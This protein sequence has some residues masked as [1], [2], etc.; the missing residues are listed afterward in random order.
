M[1][2]GLSGRKFNRTSGERKALLL[3][4]AC[5]LIKHEQIKTTLPKAKDLRPYVEKLI[6]IAAKDSL[7]SRRHALIN[8]A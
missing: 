6:T 2:H 3:N 7:A 5:S 8:F 4:L 1:R